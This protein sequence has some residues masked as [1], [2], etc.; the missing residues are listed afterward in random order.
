MSREFVLEFWLVVGD[1]EKQA[2][3]EVAA[4]RDRRRGGGATGR[5]LRLRVSV[6]VRFGR[7]PDSPQMGFQG[8]GEHRSAA[9]AARRARDGR[10]AAPAHGSISQGKAENPAR[11]GRRR[12]REAG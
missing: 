11:P 8:Q 1:V 3:P 6:L 5:R 12:L 9:G 2:E 4:G 10:D 7:A